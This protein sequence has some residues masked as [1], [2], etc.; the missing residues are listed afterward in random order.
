MEEIL[1]TEY[2]LFDTLKKQRG[3]IL[4]LVFSLP[5]D[6]VSQDWKWV[7]P[8]PQGSR[9]KGLQFVD[10]TNG[11]SWTNAGVILRTTDGGTSWSDA[12]I[13]AGPPYNYLFDVKFIDGTNG[14]AVTS[15]VPPVITRTTNGGDNWTFLN[16]PSQLNNGY[17]N[18]TTVFF[19]NPMVGFVTTDMGRIFKT[20]DGGSTWTSGYFD[21]QFRSINM[22]C[23]VDTSRGF[24]IGERPLL[25]STNSGT[26]WFEDGRV[27]NGVAINFVDSVHGWILMSQDSIAIT[28]DGG[29]SWSLFFCDG[30]GD[31]QNSIAFYDTLKGWIASNDGISISSNGG[32]NWTRIQG[33]VSYN[34][35]YPVTTSRAWA[36]GGNSLF[37]QN[38]IYEST[39][40]GL[41][42]I[43][44]SGRVTE[45]DLSAVDFLDSSLGWAI[46]GT[47]ILRT[48]NSGVTWAKHFE[49]TVVF[50]D[51]AFFDRGNALACAGSRVYKTVDSGQTWTSISTG[52]SIPVKRLHFVNKEIVWSVG[53]D[54]IMN[55]TAGIALRSSNGGVGWEDRTPSSSG[56]LADVSFIDSLNGWVSQGGNSFEQAKLFRT[57]DGGASWIT[58]IDTVSDNLGTILFL[59]SLN[60]WVAAKDGILRT[61]DGGASWTRKGR[62]VTAGLTNFTFTSNVEGW[63]ISNLGEISHSTNGGET[64]HQQLSRTALGLYGIDSFGNSLWTVGSFG[65]ILRAHIQFTNGVPPGTNTVL[66]ESI[67][68]KPIYP[69]PFNGSAT[70]SFELGQSEADIKIRILNILGQVI[71]TLFAGQLDKGNGQIFWDGK[72]ANDQIVSSGVYFFVVQAGSTSKVAKV[73]LLK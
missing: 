36:T 47:T 42:W 4:A 28:E 43:E 61:T 71:K 23:F 72:N 19:C 52:Y 70:L 67:R 51:I 38:R 22:I 60:G 35:I 15:G 48:T 6:S 65:S 34:S 50:S 31:G 57:T 53:G 20:A 45:S 49:D 56:I 12:S 9:Y 8:T 54:Y 2:P 26:S 46:G 29:D 62:P 3:L 39:D 16:I 5:I 10:S 68:L 32:R 37:L 24:A 55:G 69:N 59:D 11:W 66:P 13:Q 14:W 63:A 33:T 18:L 30:A 40:G 1:H 41:S 64:W 44:R 27:Q 7:H 17:Y 73:C 25:R 21:F 58:Q